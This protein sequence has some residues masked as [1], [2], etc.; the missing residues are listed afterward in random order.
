MPGALFKC[1]NNS[2]QL[3]TYLKN[4]LVIVILSISRHLYCCSEIVS[5]NADANKNDRY[6]LIYIPK[7]QQFDLYT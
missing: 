7:N 5:E 3:L 2:D 6:F 1:E 4:H